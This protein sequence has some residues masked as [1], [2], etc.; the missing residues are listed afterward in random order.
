MLT[1][2]AF[3]SFV[4]LTQITTEGATQHDGDDDECGDANQ[5]ALHRGQTC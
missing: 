4:F 5:L 1:F 2:S 3:A